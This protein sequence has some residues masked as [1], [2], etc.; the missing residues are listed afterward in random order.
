MIDSVLAMCWISRPVGDE[1]TIEMMSDF[2]NWII[3]GEDSS[4]GPS[5]HKR[6][7]DVFLDATVDDSDVCNWR[8]CTDVE[9]S[10]GADL[11]DE[12]DLL[13]VDKGLVFVLV[14]LL[15]NGQSG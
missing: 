9:G 13:R 6:A 12:I 8:W 7:E 3:V 14:V 4:A 15:T 11:A 10:L 2:V 5:T 1:D